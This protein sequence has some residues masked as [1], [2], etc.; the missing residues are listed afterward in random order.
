MKVHG[1]FEEETSEIAESFS[2]YARGYDKHAHLQKLMAERLASFL[3]DELPERILEIGCGTGL[4]TRHLL[5]RPTRQLTIN[6]I[7]PKMIQCLKEKLDLPSQCR[8]A[9]GNAESMKFKPVELIAANAVFQWFNSPGES[10][11]HLTR[12]LRPNGRIIFS[13]FGPATLKEFRETAELDS[14]VSL[15][16]FNRWKQLIRRAGLTL[17]SS[18]SELRKSFSPSSLTLLKN[19]Q[20]TGAA[21]FRMTRP[22]GLRHLIRQYDTTFSTAQ[23]VYST[24]EL[25]Y[26]ST[27]LK[28]TGRRVR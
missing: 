21:P 20:Q 15:L 11:N 12:F 22:G 27:T 14:P 5:T 24:W 7:A 10:L 16:S 13:T 6:D 19:L 26:F 2:K 1:S 3:P 4:F 18:A 28:S 8:I 25:Y 17:D 9:M 23:G